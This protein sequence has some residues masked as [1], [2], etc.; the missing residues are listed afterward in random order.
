MPPEKA[1]L[2]QDLISR[3]DA[4]VQQDGFELQAEGRETTW[5]RKQQ[6]GEASIHLNA[7][8]KKRSWRLGL[9]LRQVYV[10]AGLERCVLR[11]HLQLLNPERFAAHLILADPLD[12]ERRTLDLQDGFWNEVLPFF[13]AVDTIQKGIE[14]ILQHSDWFI[15]PSRWK[16]FLLAD[17]LAGLLEVSETTAIRQRI[18]AAVQHKH[19]GNPEMLASW[20]QVQA[21]L[22]QKRP[23]EYD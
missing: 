12:L 1:K 17:Q 2:L 20:E 7:S 9:T 11:T 16:P 10:D 13:A 18:A 14:V 15:G 8:F 21:S 22:L 6:A 19:A 23:P 4:L 5:V 3:F